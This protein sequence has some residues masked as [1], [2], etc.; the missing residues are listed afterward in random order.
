MA[1]IPGLGGFRPPERFYFVV[2]ALVALSF[3]AA[4]P[5]R[6]FAF[7]PHA[8]GDPRKPR[9]RRVHRASM[10]AATSSPPSSWPACSPGW[11]APCSASST[12]ASSPISLYWTKSAEVL[13]M[14]ILGGMGIFWGPARGR[15]RADA[16][17]PADHGL[18]PI[19]AFRARRRP[20]R[21]AVRFSRRDRRRALS[22]AA[23]RLRA[24]LRCASSA[25]SFGGF[26][27]VGGVSLRRARRARS[28][29][30]SA[31]TAPASRPCSIW[32]PAI[33]GP[34]TGR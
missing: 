20:H 15:A 3:V 5:H 27:A 9:A 29:R 2:L 26:T 16:P 13:I 22:A 21:S 30:S 6:R 23:R 31:R 24:C 11:R 17:E 28:P 32:L 8:D 33:S 12:G 14:T 10:C 19:L 1:A 25:R 7:R 18:Y 34:T 4:A